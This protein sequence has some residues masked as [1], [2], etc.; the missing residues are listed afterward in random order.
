MLDTSTGE[1]TGRVEGAPTST[2]MRA[3]RPNQPVPEGD[4]LGGLLRNASWGLQS[5]LFA[6][7]DAATL[8]IGRA[9]G[10]KENEVFTL[11]KFFNKNVSKALTGVE[12]TAPRDANERYARAIFEGIGGTMPFTG[13]LAYAARARPMVTTAQT[14]KTGVL[15][16]IADDAIKFVQKSPALAAGIDIAFGAGYEGMRQAVTE[17]VSDDNPNKQLYENLLPMGAFIGLPLALNMLPSVMAGKAVKNKIKSATAGLGDTNDEVLGELG[18]V[19]KLPGVRIVPKLLLKNAEKK[20]EQVFGPIAESK[21]AQ[22]ALRQLELALQDPRVAEAGFIFGKDG[23]PGSFDIAE[24]TMY[25]PL[26]AKK[27]E[28]LQQLG[29]KELEATKARI[30]ENQQKLQALMDNLAPEARQPIFEAF[31]AAQAERQSFFENLL[32]AKKDMTEA[33]ILAVSERLGPQNMDMINNELRGALMGAMEFDYKMR[34]NTLRLMGLRQATSPDGLPMPTRSEG[35]SLYPARDMENAATR[36]IDKYTPERPSLRNPVPEPI[37]FL[38]DFV[39]VQQAARDRLE[40][41]MIKDLTDEAV[42][43]QLA[44]LPFPPTADMQE[45]VRNAALA[46]M[47]GKQTKGTKRKSSVGEATGLTKAGVTKIPLG[48]GRFITVNPS[49][50]RGDAAL[51]AADSASININLPE[52]LDYLASAARFRNDA[53]ARYNSAMG[54]GGTRLTDAQRSLDTGTAVYNDIEKLILDHV[55]KIRTEYEGMKNV[56]AD[57]RAGFEQSL[58]LLMA[59]KTGRGDAFLLGNEQLLQKAFSNANN[60]RQLQVSLSGT[61]GFDDLLMKGTVDWLR[62]KGVVNENGL[63]DPKKIR[64]VLD[65]NKNIVEALPDTVQA[66]LQSEVALANDYVVRMG[67]IDARRVAAGNDELD[68]MLKRVTRPDADPRQTLAKAV[69]D[70]ATMRVLVDELGKN[71]EQL[72]ALRRS[73]YDMAS[74]GA[75]G[76]G[77]LKTFIDNNERSLKVLF[78]DTQHLEDLKMLADLQRRVNA[79]ADVTGQVPAFDSLDDTLKRVMGSGIGVMSTTYRSVAEGRLSPTTGAIAFLVRLTGALETN[80]YKRIFTK[81]LEDPNF[82]RAI[83]HVSTPADGARLS[84]EL[85]KIGVPRSMLEARVDRTARQELA[86]FAVGDQET[87]IP[88]MAQAPVVSRETAASMLRALPPAPPTTGL[89]QLRI[90]VKQINNSAPNM[91]LM[92]PALFPDDPISGLILQRQQQMRQGQPMQQMQPMPPQQ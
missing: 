73:V 9:L 21:E 16:G 25:P 88:G 59:Q 76:G 48:G 37:A 77:A 72:A 35:Q 29:P 3:A 68:Q 32:R 84:A 24:S 85:E 14:V 89:E 86:N 41:Q 91:Q 80:L 79:F 45:A 5:A 75:A 69:K 47:R 34:D 1:I 8:G 31:Q 30:N 54:K 82:A 17:N 49:Q 22:Q 44:S 57:Y 38:R 28:L 67:E 65:K 11:G 6:L 27:A 63:V 26:L 42:S 55:P 52:A 23:T 7:P 36:L 81:A 40:S 83:T 62:T 13:V 20:L 70:P 15:R 4:R 64:S 60:L 51:I 43:K 87:P 46:L 66:K 50:I 92:Y 12:E 53:L 78:K 18:G 10:M 56:L 19:W 71:P 58:P 61:P 74:E 2:N 33:E 39:Q 90:P